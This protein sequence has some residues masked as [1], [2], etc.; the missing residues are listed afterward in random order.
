M[1]FVRCSGVIKLHISLIV[2]VT[3]RS[4]GFHI[5]ELLEFAAN[6]VIVDGLA[7]GRVPQ[8]DQKRALKL[9]F[10]PTAP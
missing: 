1:R 10:I 8:C 3:Y 6:F 2:S 5:S 7:R 4:N 9:I